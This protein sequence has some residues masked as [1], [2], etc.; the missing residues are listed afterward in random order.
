MS[1][2][3]FPPGL[4][5]RCVEAV[6]GV[7]VMAD[8]LG[9]PE[10]TIADV[11]RAQTLA[12]LRAAAVPDMIDALNAVIRDNMT[13]VDPRLPSETI[14]KARAALAKANGSH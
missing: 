2:K 4:V 11:V 7:R 8:D 1:E 9:K 3:D 14:R 5:D 6:L 13:D 10:L 12:S